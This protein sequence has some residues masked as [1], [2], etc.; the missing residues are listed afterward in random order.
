MS[1]VSV[2]L[3]L[4]VCTL[5][6]VSNV[7]KSSSKKMARAFAEGV[8]IGCYCNVVGTIAYEY[9][10]RYGTVVYLTIQGRLDT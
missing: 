2:R 4:R 8:F 5:C 10:L 7:S 6:T 3:E 9:T 1:R